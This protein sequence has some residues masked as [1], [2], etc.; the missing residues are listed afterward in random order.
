ML[1]LGIDL[2]WKDGNPSG[3][4]VIN[5]S[6]QILHSSCNSYS[7]REIV[8]FIQDLKEQV[9]VSIDSPLQ[10]KNEKGGRLC[11]S[12]LMK[13]RFH[14]RS[15]KVFATSREYMKRHYGGIRGEELLRELESNCGLKLGESVVETFPTG[16]VISLFPHLYDRKYKIS[17]GLNL[18]KLIDNH[19][20]LVQCLEGLGFN[21]D[22]PE[23]S[24]MKT[25][26]EYKAA[27]DQIDGILC[28]VNSYYYQNNSF[29]QFG[30]G[31]NG[32]TVIASAAP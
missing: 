10:V 15:V 14:G 18:D 8:K 25:K 30:N 21:G 16:I 12:D 9:V 26:K 24:I 13:Y 11:D 4:S 29:V 17:S 32:L 20:T 27:E 2:A 31:E 22:Y 28:A 19:N 5:E 23:V 6:K 1:Y 3:L 7:N